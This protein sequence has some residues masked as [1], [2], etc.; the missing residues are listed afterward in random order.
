MEKIYIVRDLTKVQQDNDKKLRE[1]VKALRLAGV[2]AVRIS[3]GAV[4][5]G[6][7]GA[8]GETGLAN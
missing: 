7:G 3:R 6:D 5:R 8:G 4:V 1:E 2:A